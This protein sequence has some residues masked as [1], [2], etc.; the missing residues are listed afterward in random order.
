MTSASGQIQFSASSQREDILYHQLFK[1]PQ[2][3][4]VDKV[5]VDAVSIKL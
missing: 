4:T 2:I 5:T 3:A 1:A